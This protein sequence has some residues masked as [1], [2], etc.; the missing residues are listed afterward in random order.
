MNHNCIPTQL[1]LILLLLTI[2]IASVQGTVDTQQPG[3]KALV[4]REFGGLM[5]R[6]AT[7]LQ[8]GGFAL[9]LNVVRW[10]RITGRM[11]QI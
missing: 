11:I 1:P 2:M 3:M 5:K 8:V 7:N 4:A 10:G 6:Q 9:S